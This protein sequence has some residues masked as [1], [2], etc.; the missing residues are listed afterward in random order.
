MRV[1]I[2]AVMAACLLTSAMGFI[3]FTYSSAYDLIETLKDGDDKLY[4]LFFYSTAGLHPE[5]FQAVGH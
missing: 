3:P 4:V 5:G 1:Q 2:V